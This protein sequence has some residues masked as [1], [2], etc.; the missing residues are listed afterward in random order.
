MAIKRNKPDEIVTKLRQVEV[1]VGQGKARIDAIREIGVTKPQTG[2]FDQYPLLSLLETVS[3]RNYP[4]NALEEWHKTAIFLRFW[5]GV[6]KGGGWLVG[7][8][9]FE[10]PTRPL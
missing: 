7:P 2:T 3:G 9:G 5:I 8:G 1:L 4:E 6:G 10:P